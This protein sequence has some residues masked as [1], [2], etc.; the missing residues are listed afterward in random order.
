MKDGRVKMP[1]GGFATLRVSS[2]TRERLRRLVERRLADGERATMG[3]LVDE[4][5]KAAADAEA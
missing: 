5:V 3:G 4:M 1:E 2:K